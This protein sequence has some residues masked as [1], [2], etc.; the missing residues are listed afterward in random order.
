MNV[1][2]RQQFLA[3]SGE[4]VVA[5]IGLAFR[6]MAVSAGVERDGPVAALPASVQLPTECC[7][8]AKLDGMQYAEMEPRQPG[9]VLCDESVAVLSDDISHLEGWLIHG[10][11]SFRERLI[12]SELETEIVSNGLAT[13]VR[14]FCERCRYTAVCS[15]LAW[16]SNIWIVRRSVP[17]SSRCVAK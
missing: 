15:S 9:P 4:P 13:A 12:S 3:A 1:V 8:A 16:P 7:R 5:R 11:C 6:A 10:F 17:A 14:C 2:N